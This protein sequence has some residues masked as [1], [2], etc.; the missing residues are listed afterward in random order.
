MHDSV[1][2]ALPEVE[3]NTAE[4]MTAT[5]PKPLLNRPTNRSTKPIRA[6]PMRP[7]S[8]TLPARTN[9]GMARRMV[10]LICVY[11]LASKVLG[12]NP[13]V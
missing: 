2:E 7:F 1:A 6:S 13:S 10:E 4:V 5:A 9:S 3:P 8:M 11:L 12:L